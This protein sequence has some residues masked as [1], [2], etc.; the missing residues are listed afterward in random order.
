M[1]TKL[2]ASRKNGNGSHPEAAPTSLMAEALAAIKADSD[3][4]EKAC[5]EEVQA[6]FKRHNC[7]FHVVIAGRPADEFLSCPFGVLIKSNPTA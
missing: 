4:R 6:V 1:K 2:P 3:A 5:M 7:G